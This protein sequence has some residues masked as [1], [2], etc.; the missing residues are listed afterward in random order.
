MATC[1]SLRFTAK[2]RARGTVPVSAD[3]PGGSPGLSRRP[4]R[5]AV[6][7]LHSQCGVGQFAGRNLGLVE[8]GVPGA[9]AEREERGGGLSRWT[10]GVGEPAAASPAAA[11][12]RFQWV[13]NARQVPMRPFL[14]P[15]PDS[16]PQ[17]LSLACLGEFLSAL[18][19]LRGRRG[20]RS[21][22]HP[23]SSGW[24]TESFPV[25]GFGEGL[26]LPGSL[27]GGSGE[28]TRTLRRL[29]SQTESPASP[30][31]VPAVARWGNSGYR[32]AT[33]VPGCRLAG[34]RLRVE[35][36]A[37]QVSVLRRRL[38]PP[39]GARLLPPGAVDKRAVWC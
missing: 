24:E 15:L 4:Q 5:L 16:W 7:G 18:G 22:P 27:P 39:A 13:I 31:G 28:G 20:A 36:A 17:G 10:G 23:L 25:L 11:E 1:S 38:V 21:H 12:L 33:K 26:E 35:V 6:A 30:C 34:Q 37:P 9:W 32:E 29:V 3:G 19:V 2:G 8:A 14:P